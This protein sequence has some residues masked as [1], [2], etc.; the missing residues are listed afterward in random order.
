MA[1]RKD[2]QVTGFF[3]CC[4]CSEW[5]EATTVAVT[6]TM[7]AATA[8]EREKKKGRSLLLPT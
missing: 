5:N 2:V 7:A 6:S 3:F 8:V 4:V 1:K